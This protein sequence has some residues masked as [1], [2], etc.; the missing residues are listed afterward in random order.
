MLLSIET[1]P[2]PKLD[3]YGYAGAEYAGRDAFTNGGGKGVGYG[4]PLN[5]N[6]GCGTEAAPANDYSPAAGACTGQTRSVY[7]GN[8]G[9][10][11]R[12]YKGSAGTV[13]WGMQYSYTSRN[14]WVDANGLQPQAIENMIFSSFRY[15]LP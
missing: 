1:H 6:T 14:T 11:Y 15:V 5:L 2:M 9:F 13:Q 3:V 8:L 12:F 10:W 4:S 7:Q